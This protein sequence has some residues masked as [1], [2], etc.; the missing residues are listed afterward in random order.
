MTGTES[1]G[2]IPVSEDFASSCPA[3][4]AVWRE[5]HYN[6]S[7]RLRNFYLLFIGSF[8]MAAFIADTVISSALDNITSD[9]T[10]RFMNGTILLIA[11]DLS[12]HPRSEWKQYVAEVLDK[13]FVYR[14]DIASRQELKLSKRQLQELDEGKISL[15]QK[16]GDILYY[17]LGDTDQILI[18]GHISP[19]HNSKL[20]LPGLPLEIHARLGT[21]ILIS[22]MFGGVLRFWARPILSDLESL[23]QTAYDLGKGNLSAR[24]P[25]VRNQI[26]APLANTLDGMAERI[27]HLMAVQKELSTAISH[28]LRTPIA[29]LRFV[30]EMVAEAETPEERQRLGLMMENDLEELDKL[31]D[32]SLTYARFERE[33]MVLQPT[34][35]NIVQWLE[36]Q[37]DNMRILGQELDLR[38][39]VSQLPANFV[40]YMD[41]TR[42][43]HAINN[44]LRN[45]IRYAKRRIE[46]S[47]L[48]QDGRFVIH[49]DDDG[50][51]IPREERERI[52]FPFTRLDRSRDR[53]TGGYGLGL[54]ITRH[55]LELHGGGAAVS[56]SPLG[57]ARFTLEWPWSSEPAPPR[58]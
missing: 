7:R 54:S 40:I 51:G 37:V 20:Y 12:R 45:A 36:D 14:L 33:S 34:P 52:F 31:I 42:L 48:V 56:D 3:R 38:L 47:A 19:G 44:L 5:Q 43:S 39:D 8:V 4:Q 49:V 26:F 18:V 2:E 16:D 23:R 6:L 11:E 9:Y 27:Q 15:H 25:N 46:V 41:K 28:E 35:V 32:S 10:R 57:G 17:A 30:S 24:V 21:W 58:I 53:A 13:K 55:V 1:G 22:V 29:R 50:I